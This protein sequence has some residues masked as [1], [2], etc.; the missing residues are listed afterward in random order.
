MDAVMSSVEQ[1]S[2]NAGLVPGGR[3]TTESTTTV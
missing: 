3:V 2:A 1:R